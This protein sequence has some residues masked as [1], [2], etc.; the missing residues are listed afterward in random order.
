[1]REQ[2]AVAAV[3]EKREPRVVRD[4]HPHTLRHAFAARCFENKMEPKVVQDKIGNHCKWYVCAVCRG[5]N[6]CCKSRNG[7]F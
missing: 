7:Y 1:M 3:Q 2:E 6:M 5:F 4:F